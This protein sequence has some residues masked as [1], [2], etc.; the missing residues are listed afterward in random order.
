MTDS[1]NPDSYSQFLDLRTR[2][3]RDLLAVIPHFFQPKTV[4]DLGC[5][6]GNSTILLKERWPNASVIGLDTSSAMLEKANANY[7]GI[8]FI[9]QDIAQFSPPE[10]IDCLFANASLQWLDHHEKLIPELLQCINPGGVF[11]IQMPNNFH[12]PAH[13][14]TIRVLQANEDW[15]PYLKNLRYGKLTEPLYKLP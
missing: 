11:A 1:W 3:A 12:A 8:T 15:R 4:Y 5:G 13:Q 14:T 9:K 2:P 6:T 10:K 7:P